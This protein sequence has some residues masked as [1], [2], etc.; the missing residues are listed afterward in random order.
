MPRDIES[1]PQLHKYVWKY[2]ELIR[3]GSVY[4][5]KS[6]QESAHKILATV[7]PYVGTYDMSDTDDIAQTLAGDTKTYKSL[8]A[9]LV[10]S[11]VNNK[12]NSTTAD[13]LARTIG[14][15]R[16]C[17]LIRDRRVR[18]RLLGLKNMPETAHNFIVR[19]IADCL[20]DHDARDAQSVQRE[21]IAHVSRNPMNLLDFPTYM[22]VI[23][24]AEM[25][26]PHVWFEFEN[27]INTETIE[28][29][30]HRATSLRNCAVLYPHAVPI[31][32][33]QE[34]IFRVAN[35]FALV[36][37]E[38]TPEDKESLQVDPAVMDILIKQGGHMRSMAHYKVN[39]EDYPQLL[40]AATYTSAGVYPYDLIADDDGASFIQSL[41]G[42]DLDAT[43]S[44]LGAMAGDFGSFGTPVSAAANMNRVLTDSSAPKKIVDLVR[45]TPEWAVKRFNLY[46]DAINKTDRFIAKFPENG[47]LADWQKLLPQ[48]DEQHVAQFN[49]ISERMRKES[50]SVKPTSQMFIMFA[51]GE[52]KDALKAA[53]PPEWLTIEDL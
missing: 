15:R 25:L 34:R 39:L 17:S 42:K 31:N 10:D 23:S 44:L 2:A 12:D 43:A 37:G 11:V 48:M 16:F 36:I 24:N 4:G 51:Q 19:A 5:S 14:Y 18:K 30:M 27:E 20:S 28:R 9:W 22:E 52:V 33:W 13:Y 1:V 6:Y 35:T 41:N 53:I 7:K 32:E 8:V 3:E 40:N 45:A 47:T 50:R 49:E 26:Y 21:L 46:I 38:P 29:M